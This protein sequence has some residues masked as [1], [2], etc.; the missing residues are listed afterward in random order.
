[1]MIPVIDLSEISGNISKSSEPAPALPSP[2]T[3]LLSNLDCD[4]NFLK[5]NRNILYIQ[6]NDDNCQL[7][8]IIM[9]KNRIF[10]FIFFLK[11]P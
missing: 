7:L 9:I 8:V 5:K 11:I 3:K 2:V 10:C 4:P 6:K 1:M